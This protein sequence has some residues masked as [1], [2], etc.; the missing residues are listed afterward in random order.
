MTLFE[1]H[2]DM[3]QLTFQMK[4][5]ADVLERLIPPAVIHTPSGTKAELHQ[6]QPRSRWEAEKEDRR[7]RSVSD[8]VAAVTPRR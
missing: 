6:V 1:L 7:W 3:E 5:I 2:A 4:R 8:E